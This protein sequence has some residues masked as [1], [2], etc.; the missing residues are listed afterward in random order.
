MKITMETL[1]KLHALS[2]EF[3]T[4]MR[5]MPSGGKDA[6]A[7]TSRI[8]KMEEEKDTPQS[9]YDQIKNVSGM[10]FD[11]TSLPIFTDNPQLQYSP[12]LLSF[13]CSQSRGIPEFITAMF[14]LYAIKFY[15]DRT[16]SQ[17]ITAKWVMD[18]I[19]HG[20]IIGHTHMYPYAM[21]CRYGKKSVFE[22]LEPWDLFPCNTYFSDFNPKGGNGRHGGMPWKQ[23]LEKWQQQQK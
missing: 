22:Q 17:Q 16:S 9:V 18:Q 12:H 21:A 23:Q 13:I 1:V 4:N 20:K 19:G 7:L 6:E 8:V 15:E 11:A 5:K 2:D 10:G 3:I 14:G